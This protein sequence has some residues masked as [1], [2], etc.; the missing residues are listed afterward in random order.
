M[1]R[2]FASTVL[3][4]ETQH[5]L[6]I[7]HATSIAHSLTHKKARTQKKQTNN[8]TCTCH[9][10]VCVCSNCAIKPCKRTHDQQKKKQHTQKKTQQTTPTRTTK[11]N[12]RAGAQ[13]RTQSIWPKRLRLRRRAHDRFGNVKCVCRQNVWP[14]VVGG[15]FSQTERN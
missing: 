11:K 5:V 3:L 12:T 14:T 2:K 4:F 6:C 1:G 15:G 10:F 13:A 7:A 8:F 9:Y